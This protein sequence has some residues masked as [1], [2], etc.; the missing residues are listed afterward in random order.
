MM[1]EKFSTSNG[2]MGIKYSTYAGRRG[3]QRSNRVCV[4]RHGRIA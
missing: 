4:M 2:E 1:E 3:K